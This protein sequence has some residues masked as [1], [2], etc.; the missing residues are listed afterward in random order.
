M[1]L[2][3]FIAYMLISIPCAYIFAFVLDMGAVGIWWS[4]PFGLSTAA[5]CYYLQFS[6]C[7]RQKN[8]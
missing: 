4:F 8:S 6:R 7:L 3:A 1:M 2:Y 5:V